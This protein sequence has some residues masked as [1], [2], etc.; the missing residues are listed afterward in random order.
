VRLPPGPTAAPLAQTILF[1]RDPLGVLS[2]L[3]AR[4]G[5]VFSFRLVV[6]G[7]QVAV[8]DPDAIRWLLESDPGASHAG[9]AR[10]RVLPQASPSSVFGAD[11]DRYE[12]AH[13]RLADAFAPD[14]VSRHRAAMA[15]IAAEH[16]ASWPRGRPF[17]LL[18]RVRALIDDVFVRLVL[19]VVDERR[20]DEL[21]RAIGRMLWTPGNPPMPI[22]GEGD[23]AP[24]AV[25]KAA[26]DRLQ[27]PVSRL[28]AE[29]IEARRKAAGD[30]DRDVIPSILGAAPGL[31]TEAIVDE[32]IAILAAAQEPP[33]IA[34]TWL[35]DRL[36]RSPES[37]RAYLA[38]GPGDAERDA[39]VRE[40]LRLRPPALAALR[41]LTEPVRI[42]GHPIPAGTVT[43][44]PIPLVQRDPR[45]FREPDDFRP[46]RWSAPVDERTYL[47]FGGGARRCLGEHLARAYFDSVVPAVAERLE[48]RPVGR[49]PERMVVRATT[50]VPHRSAMVMA[51]R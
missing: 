18:P 41:L 40:T 7:D 4:H 14:A 39:I 28:L 36:G 30:G 19:G 48:L 38:A 3:R 1:H 22:P 8:A 44:I 46:E 37:A 12:K 2:R 21:P 47:P 11:G 34:I 17:R 5:E 45:F 51:P 31:P 15:E 29:E 32:L 6:K 50:L 33:S 10:R 16:A 43:M 26:F 25:G 24:G 49:R 13:S 23:S 35:L 20:R 27:A 42:A 9:E